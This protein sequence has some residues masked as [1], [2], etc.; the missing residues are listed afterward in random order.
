MRRVWSFVGAKK[1][2]ATPEQKAEGWGDVWTWTAIDA[3][4]KLCVSYLGG[5]RDAGWAADFL[6]DCA[7]RLRTRV[8]LTTDAH[9]ACLDAVEEAFGMEVDCATL[10]KIY[11]APS[12]EEARR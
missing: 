4:S 6:K 10:Q 12:D 3:D 7:S 1:K 2:N 9:K 5:G 11:G 8:Q